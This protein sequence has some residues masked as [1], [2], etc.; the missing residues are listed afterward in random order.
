M[1]GI[2]SSFLGWVGLGSGWR[3]SDPLLPQSR[4]FGRSSRPVNSASAYASST[5]QAFYA[6]GGNAAPVPP[7]NHSTTSHQHL[8]ASIRHNEPMVTVQQQEEEREKIT[9]T[10]RLQPAHYTSHPWYHEPALHP[11]PP[12]A[13]AP[14]YAAVAGGSQAAHLAASSRLPAQTGHGRTGFQPAGGPQNAVPLPAV[15]GAPLQPG[16]RPPVAPGGGSD[17]VETQH[18]AY[19]VSLQQQIQSMNGQL[20]EAQR[21]AVARNDIA[22]KLQTAEEELAKT[23]REVYIQFMLQ[24]RW[25]SMF[26]AILLVCAHD[27]VC[28][29]CVNVGCL[30]L[31]MPSMVVTF[32]S[33]A[34]W[35]RRFSSWKST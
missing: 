8:A 7:S 10:P 16:R 20:Q 23:R 9:F 18:G 19:I 26:V 31:S 13:A 21:A 12:P 6:A 1:M 11:R 30:W 24:L 29:M 17:P 28:A 25:I 5:H 32:R 15:L 22:R 35:N 34:A 4:P 3:H 14:S 27:T 33:A 2:I